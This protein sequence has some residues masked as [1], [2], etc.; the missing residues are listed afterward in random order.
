MPTTVTSSIGTGGGRTYSTISA[1]EDATD[2]NLVTADQVQVGECYNDSAFSEQVVMAGATV[3]ATRYRHLTVAA[4]HSFVDH[5]DRLTNP[6]RY[7]QS[8][9]VGIA[10]ASG[11]IN[12]IIE[13][14]ENYFR[15]SR[16][17][18]N[19]TG[20]NGG[21][22]YF[23]ADNCLISQCII[24]STDTSRA[25]VN[26][27]G[28][29][30]GNCEINNSIV[31]RRA[32]SSAVMISIFVAGL[33]QNCTFVVPS[34]ISANA[35]CVGASYPSAITYRN[36]AFFGFTDVG[37]TTGHTYTNCRANDASPPSGVTTTT[38]DTSTGSGFENT[39]DATR[40]FRIKST[41]ALVNAGSAT[42]APSVDIVG[43]S[44]PQGAAVDIGAWEYSSAAVAAS[45]LAR[46]LMQRVPALRLR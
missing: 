16:F 22:V 33:A 39:T 3:D 8:K 12:G 24:E 18:I 43:T 13:S 45:L 9:G 11:Y 5:A 32:S 40:D 2:V 27:A 15:L 20:S 4:G 42:G 38:Y 10:L 46:N 19:Y 44:R 26:L 23:G 35:T 7:D 31:V 28:A 21:S 36:C 14:T 1:W 30:S 34:S 17:Q 29:S 37:T 41:S 25:V 6:L